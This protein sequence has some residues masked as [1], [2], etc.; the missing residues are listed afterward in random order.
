M[1]QRDNAVSTLGQVPGQ[2]AAKQTA[3]AGY[4]NPHV[5]KVPWDRST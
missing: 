1:L 2:L 4:K 5:Q 3:S